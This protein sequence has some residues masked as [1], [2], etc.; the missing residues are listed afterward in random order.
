[1]E[2]GWEQFLSLVVALWWA[3]YHLVVFVL[4][5]VLRWSILIAWLAWWLCGVNWARVW[6]VLA[7]GA[8]LGV[9]L[10]NLIAALVWSQM[11]PSSCDCLGLLTVGNFWWQLGA[12]GLLTALTL[13]CG[14]LQG[15]LSWAP[16][17]I[18]LEPVAEPMHPSH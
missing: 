11:E 14:W 3:L 17:E 8:W 9:V 13:F 2:T 16:P 18:A 7:Q 10:L 12:V 1:V 15:A 5:T 6:P 4:D